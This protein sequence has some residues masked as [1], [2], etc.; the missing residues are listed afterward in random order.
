MVGL[1]AGCAS[2]GPVGPPPVQVSDL[3]RAFLLPVAALYPAGAGDE[4]ARL[5][6][7]QAELLASG[8]AVAARRVAEEVLASDPANDAAAVLLGQIELLD[9]NYGAV[10]SRLEPI[11]ERQPDYLTA[12]LLLAHNEEMLGDLV[13]AVVAFRRVEE[14]AGRQG[15]PEIAGLAH[16]RVAALRTR[17]AEALTRRIPELLAAGRVAE[18]ERQLDLLRNWQ[19]APELRLPA[20]RA[21]AE[22]KGDRVGE[23]AA[24]RGLAGQLDRTAVEGTLLARWADLELEVGDAAVGLELAQEL[25]RRSPGDSTNRERLA[26]ARFAWRLQ[27]L[28]REVRDLAAAAELRRADLAALLYWLVPDVRRG[29][30][31]AGTV[32]IASDVLDHPQREAIVR[33][34]NLSLM[35]VDETLHRFNPERPARRATALA[36]SLRLLARQPRPPAC[37]AGA[38]AAA[39]PASEAVC[40]AA[41]RCGLLDQLE[42]CLPNGPLAGSEAIEWIRQIVELGSGT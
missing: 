28:P 42:A 15:H 40:G 39:L 20:E 32:R 30:S 25:E 22:A 16:E 24:L 37:L 21:V 35:D 6:A 38:G 33:V 10:R 27:L 9:R 17:A 29:G 2:G 31:G 3:D 36:A 18:A 11:V 26:R 19:V 4:G 1:L 8:A 14:I 41:L 7:A 12:W 13:R 23:L 34:V 5:D